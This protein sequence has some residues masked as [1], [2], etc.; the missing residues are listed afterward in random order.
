[1]RRGGH[2]VL[3]VHYIETDRH[4]EGIGTGLYERA[5]QD[6]CEAGMMLASPKYGR[7][8][9]SGGFWAKQQRKGRTVRLA[10]DWDAIDCDYAGDLS[11]FNPQPKH[12]LWLGGGLAQLTW[13]RKKVR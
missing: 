1:M 13:A 8:A 3:Q 12:L 9:K 11:G 4:R 10:E 6:A 2:P 5:A 7:N